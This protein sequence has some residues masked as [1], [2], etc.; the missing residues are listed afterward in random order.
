MQKVETKEKILMSWATGVAGQGK[1][2]SGE[3]NNVLKEPKTPVLGKCNPVA[4]TTGGAG[5][6]GRINEGIFN[7][8]T[9]CFPRKP[10][11]PQNPREDKD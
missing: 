6:G 2:L 10:L 11:P 4:P 8:A 9:S 5:V 7:A 1:S 3:K